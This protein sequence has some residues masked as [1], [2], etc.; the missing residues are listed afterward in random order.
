MAKAKKKPAPKA[1]PEKKEEPPK[2]A[3][4]AKKGRRK[5]W[6]Q[7]SIAEKTAFKKRNRRVI[8]ATVS[9]AV[10]GAAAAI[11]HYCVTGYSFSALLCAALAGIIGFCTFLPRLIP[12]SKGFVHMI[13]FLLTLV[14]IAAGITEYHIIQASLGSPATQ[15]D[16]LVVLGAKV[17]DDGPSLS[18][19]NRIDAAFDY[20]TAHPDTIAVVS[21][22]Q[23]EDEPMSEAK[24]MRDALVER[25]IDADRIWTEDKAA[26]TWENLQ[27]SLSLIEE[28][29]GHRPSE[30][31]VV[32]SE[33]H[34]FRAGLFTEAAGA[35]FIGIP[36]KTTLPVLKV[37]YFLR[38]VAGVWHYYLLGGNYHA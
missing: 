30:I 31:A 7:M 5:S 34:L 22:G 11:F 6:H 19:T 10:L 21:G 17:R 32:S 25:G 20:L 29:T 28:K 26:S 37:N 1:A 23:G 8:V 14:F 38:E 18:L 12:K 13:I 2:K 36:A 4:P 3:A 27:F 16:Y 33:Y 15:C 9:M 24:A 35:E